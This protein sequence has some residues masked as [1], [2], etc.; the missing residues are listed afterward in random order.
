MKSLLAKGFFFRIER[1]SFNLFHGNQLGIQKGVSTIDS[2]IDPYFL[3]LVFSVMD[4][5]MRYMIFSILFAS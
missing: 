3:G 2:E 1:C 4:N 5:R